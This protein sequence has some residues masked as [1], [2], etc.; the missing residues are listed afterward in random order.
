M[1]MRL[2]ELLEHSLLV[3]THTP[4]KRG[5]LARPCHEASPAGFSG[6]APVNDASRHLAG[7]TVG[8]LSS[9]DSGLYH[10]LN[11]RLTLLTIVLYCSQH[12][13]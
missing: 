12:L 3:T 5:R 9:Y 10:G 1:V 11:T 13:V 2:T 8:C 4:P 7:M 6:S